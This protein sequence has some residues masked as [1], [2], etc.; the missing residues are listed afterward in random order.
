MKFKRDLLYLLVIV[1]LIGLCGQ[2]YYSYRYK[3]AHEIS[4]YYNHDHELNNEIIQLTRDA[5]KFVYFS[6]YTFT[7]EDIKDALLAAKYRGL[8][9]TGLTDK[10]Q[11]NSLDAQKKLIDELKSSDIPVYVQNHSGIMHTKVI[12]TD[13]GYASGSYNWTTAA[14]NINDEV[15]EVGHDEKIRQKFQDILEEM[16]SKYRSI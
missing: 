10:D 3:P 4:V 2:F 15:L 14:T 1:L 9:V 13:K 6:V 8:T 5:D 11:Y 7:R 16:F 12:V